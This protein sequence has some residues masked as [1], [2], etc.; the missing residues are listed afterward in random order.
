MDPDIAGSC[1]GEHEQEEDEAGRLPVVGGDSLGAEKDCLQKA[2]LC[3]C[4]AGGQHI[5]DT[6][7]VWCYKYVCIRMLEKTNAYNQV[8]SQ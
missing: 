2:A 1:D 7:I 6:P 3:T 5:R 8:H 4:K